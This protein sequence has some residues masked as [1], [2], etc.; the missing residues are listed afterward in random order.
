MTNEFTST[1]NRMLMLSGKSITRVA[2]LA[3]LDRAFVHRIFAGERMPSYVT[4]AKVWWA[5]G[6]DERLIAKDPTMIHGLAELVLAAS[7]V[8]ATRSVGVKMLASAD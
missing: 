8:P 6:V 5:L 7:M 2:A 4:L 1:L 3:E